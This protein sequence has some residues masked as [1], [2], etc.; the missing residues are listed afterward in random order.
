[1]TRLLTLTAAAL[2]AAAVPPTAAFADNELRGQ[3]QMVSVDVATVEVK[4]VTDKKLARKGTR[5]VVRGSG[6]TTKVTAAGLHGRDYRY[7]A[8]VKVRPDLEPG[9]KYTVRFVL[10]GEDSVERKVLLRAGS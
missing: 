8:R 1:M 3:P 6:T 2:A 7:V 4:F 10:D 9:T 5:I